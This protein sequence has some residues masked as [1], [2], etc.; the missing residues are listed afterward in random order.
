ME[1]ARKLPGGTLQ[2][3]PDDQAQ[4]L[5]WRLSPGSPLPEGPGFLGGSDARHIAATAVDLS[6]KALERE[7]ATLS[8]S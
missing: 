4:M 5:L 1:F 3:S 6:P 2:L 8:R 7:A